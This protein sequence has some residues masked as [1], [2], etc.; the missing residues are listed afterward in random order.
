MGSYRPRWTARWANLSSTETN[1]HNKSAKWANGRSKAEMAKQQRAAA[2]AK[3]LPRHPRALSLSRENALSH[4]LSST[5][6]ALLLAV[7]LSLSLSLSL[8][9]CI[10]HAPFHASCGSAV[11]FLHLMMIHSWKFSCFCWKSRAVFSA[12][13]PTLCLL[14]TLS[15]QLC[16]YNIRTCRPANVALHTFP[17]TTRYFHVWDSQVFFCCMITTHRKIQPCYSFSRLVSW[18]VTVGQLLPTRRRRR[19]IFNKLLY[20]PSEGRWQL[21]VCLGVVVLSLCLGQWIFTRS[22]PGHPVTSSSSLSRIGFPARRQ[23]WRRQVKWPLS[24]PRWPPTC[25]FCNV[26]GKCW[27]YNILVHRGCSQ[28]ATGLKKF[29]F[30]VLFYEIRGP[31]LW[32]THTLACVFLCSKKYLKKCLETEKLSSMHLSMSE[33]FE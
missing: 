23:R 3:S 30:N 19:M 14:S 11:F 6:R 16:R 20:W 24:L 22:T 5:A 10:C 21:V 33:S 18:S 26:H 12:N 2:A 28:H 8:Y 13:F 15:N 4:S 32:S 1:G 31:L 7:A 9:L 17:I 25:R 29:F 27:K